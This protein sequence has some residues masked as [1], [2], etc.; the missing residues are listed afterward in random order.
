MGFGGRLGFSGRFIGTG[1]GDLSFRAGRSDFAG[2][3]LAGSFA[4]LRS[5]F[6]FSS[7]PRNVNPIR[8]AVVASATG[9][10]SETGR[11][12]VVRLTGLVSP[13]GISAFFLADFRVGLS[14]ASALSFFDAA[15]R[16]LGLTVD[17][18]VST[19]SGA[20]PSTS[21]FFFLGIQKSSA[22][23]PRLREKRPFLRSGIELE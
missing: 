20:V 6:G 17:S 15:L 1:F 19:F 2:R 16:V 3:F 9:L 8:G 12:R 21:S 23:Q 14:A 5:V 18:V 10:G 4:L 11:L 22:A 13:A 7:D